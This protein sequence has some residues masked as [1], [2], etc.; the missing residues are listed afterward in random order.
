MVEQDPDEGTAVLEDKPAD[1][2]TVTL[3]SPVT[4]RRRLTYQPGRH[5]GRYE[6]REALAEGGMGAVYAA[7]DPQLGRKIALKFVRVSGRNPASLRDARERLL[8][9]AQAI[10]QLSHPNVVAAH[11]VGTAD[12]D[13]FIA[14]ELVDGSTLREWLTA[15]PRRL[16]DKL[17]VMIDA[18]RGLAAAHRAGLVHRDFKPSNVLVGNDGRVR[19]VDFGLARSARGG[20]AADAETTPDHDLESSGSGPLGAQLTQA[21]MILG[22]P[23]YMSPEQF[24]GADVDAKSDQYS[25]AVT[26]Y[27]VVYGERPFRAPTRAELEKLIRAGRPVPPAGAVAPAWLRKVIERGMAVDPSA[28]FPSMDALLAELARDHARTR[29]RAGLAAAAVVVLGG[30]GAIV[31]SGR[32]DRTSPCGGAADELAGVWNG[33][34]RARIQSAFAATGRPYAAAMSGRVAALLDARGK[35]WISMRTEACEATRVHGKQSEALLDLRMRCLDRRLAE[36]RTVSEVLA[37]ANPNVVDRSVD[38]VLGLERLSACADPDYVASAFPPP[39]D[40]AR[41]HEIAALREHLDRSNVVLNAG[42][43]KGA[44]AIAKQAAADAKGTQYAP[45]IA[46]AALRLGWAEARTGDSSAGLIELEHAAT[47]A[48]GAKADNV[49]AEASLTAFYVL[50]VLQARYQ[51]ALAQKDLVLAV[52]ARAGD[53]PEQRADAL[54]TY[55]YLLIQTGDAPKAI[56]VL[57]S[58]RELFTQA[59]G[60]D[61]PHVAHALNYLAMAHNDAGR[62]ADGRAAMERALAIWE[63]NFGPDNPTLISGHINLASTLAEQDALGDAST[64]AR[65]ALAI[66]EQALGPDH[67][68]TA[69]ALAALGEIEAKQGKCQDA[70]PR[71]ARALAIIEARSGPTHPTAAYPL[72]TTGQC[73][74]ELGRPRE[75]IAPLER[76]LVIRTDAKA[77]P[78]ELAVAQFQLA[79]AL[80]ERGNDRRRARSLAQTAHDALATAGSARDRDRATITAW[81]ADP[82]HAKF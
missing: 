26:L 8:R 7:Y 41:V 30:A 10:A 71:L 67:P 21:G 25:F 16:A 65:R 1:D 62:F 46:E 69:I 42:D 51:E 31:W 13:V 28:R 9:E 3:A 58:A 34:A 60:P 76:A 14:M 6:I 12:G 75:A 49:L 18:G 37:G 2:A 56:A 59:D 74:V 39:S 15:E 20:A 57:E 50:A 32:R 33:V 61:H 38:A 72:V 64:H 68:K 47:V 70:L 79:R 48:G 22:T 78:T 80:W 77:K 43:Y 35:D 66:A 4:R 81:L 55:G 11:D 44:L 54:S 24:R 36:I 82:A 73:L 5:V 45:V 52:V 27:E 19:I 40:P 63:H 53:R 29:R 23:Q 17:S